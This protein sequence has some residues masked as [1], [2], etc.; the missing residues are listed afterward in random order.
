MRLYICADMEGIAGVAS[1]PQLTPEGFEFERAREWMTG[2]VNAAI[3][4]ARAAGVTDIVISDSH[5]TGQNLLLDALPDDVEV[6]RSWPRPLHMMQGVEDAGTIGAFLIGQHSGNTDME[7][8]LAHTM[9]GAA[10]SE[11]RLNG[12]PA[13]E[14]RI[15]GA[16]AGHFGVPVL[17]AT[18]DAAYADHARGLFGAIET[19]ATKTWITD[20]CNR[21]MMPARARQLIEA[22]ASRAIANRAAAAPYRI[23]GPITLEIVWKHRFPSQVLAMLPGFERSGPS[24]MRMVV[25]DMVAVAGVIAAV[26]GYDT[27]RR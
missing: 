23:A 7:G 27:S 12:E 22:A 1:A 19:V 8:T 9:M 13:S 24:T 14:T 5:G 2:E 15:N 17:L 21:T 25:D 11:I 26:T 18:G 16:I 4:G 3:R 10:I 6:V 20:H